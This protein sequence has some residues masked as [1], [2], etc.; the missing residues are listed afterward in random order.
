MAV[1]SNCNCNDPDGPA[2]ILVDMA[3]GKYEAKVAV[4]VAEDQLDAYLGEYELAPGFIVAIS[5]KDGQ[6]TGQATG[7]GAFPLTA[8]KEHYFANEQA[9]LEI[10]FNVA[11]DGSVPSFTLFQ[12]GERE[13]KRIK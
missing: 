12:G 4:E 1:F 5:R 10:R 7:Q 13:A 2:T 11:A 3:I 8:I 6:L 9:G